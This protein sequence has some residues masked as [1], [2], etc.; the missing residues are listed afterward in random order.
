MHFLFIYISSFFIFVKSKCILRLINLRKL[1]ANIVFIIVFCV[2]ALNGFDVQGQTVNQYFKVKRVEGS[3]KFNADSIIVTSS[4]GLQAHDTILLIQMTGIEIDQAKLVK[5]L[6]NS[7]HYEFLLIGSVPNDSIVVLASPVAREYNN[8]ELLQAVKV[9]GFTNYTVNTSLSTP[10]WDGSTGGVFA[11]ILSDTLFLQQ[12]IDVSEKGYR[13][14]APDAFNYSGNCALVTSG[15]DKDYYMEDAQDIAA[16]KGEG[17]LIISFPYTRGKGYVQQGG[18]G[19]NGHFSGGGGGGNFGL[20]GSGGREYQACTNPGAGGDGGGLDPNTYYS[21]AN[22][23]I[24]MGGGGGTSTQNTSLGKSATPGGNGGGIVIILTRVLAG[25]GH[26]ISANGGSVSGLATAGGGGGGGGGAILLDAGSMISG[27]FLNAKGGK[28]GNSYSIN[29]ERTGSGGGGGGGIVWVSSPK[30]ETI[31]VGGGASG[32]AFPDY[33]GGS[34]GAG[35]FLTG[36][37]IPLTGFLYNILP[38]DQVICQ[39]AVPALIEGTAAKGGDGIYVYKWIQSQ[40]L[41]V[42]STISGANTANYQPPALSD[43]TYYR[44]IVTSH[45]SGMPA[46]I[47]DTSKVMS[48]NV[49]PAI[50]NNLISGNDTV[51]FNNAPV[52]LKADG[53]VSG[54]FQG[55]TYQWISQTN[56]ETT[57][58]NA[59]S[60]QDSL[61]YQPPALTSTTFYRRMVT[62]YGVCVDTSNE[63]TIT[64]LDSIANNLIATSQIICNNDQP[65]KLTGNVL[66]GGDG[67]YSLFWQQSNTGANWNTV[68]GTTDQLDYLP[69]VLHDTTYYRRI[70]ISGSQDACIDTSNQL[71]INVLPSLSNNS[72]SSSQLLCENDT[73]KTL[74]GLLPD[75]GDG[76]FTYMWQ[77]S[78]DQTVWTATG[79]STVNYDP[80][81]VTNALYYRRIVL[82]GAND[83]CK[84]TSSIV[85]VDMQPA[86][87]NNQIFQDTTICSGQNPDIITGLSPQGGDGNNYS[88]TWQSSADADNWS[89][90]SGTIN[91]STYDPPV[92]TNT[93]YVRRKVESGV[94]VSNSNEITIEVLSQVSDNTILNGPSVAV[95]Y[96]T[97][98]ATLD[99]SVPSGGNEGI[100]NYEWLTSTDGNNWNVTDGNPNG[101]DYSPGALT[102]ETYYK[103][104]V[105]SGLHG[106]CVDTSSMIT[107]SINPLPTAVLQD[108]TDTLCSGEEKDLSVSLTGQSPWNLEYSDGINSISKV[109]TG[110]NSVIA[111][112]PASTATYQLVSVT[113][114]NGCAATDIK[115]TA[116]IV[117][118]PV[119]T[120]NAGDNIEECGLTASLH[121]TVTADTGYWVA[122][123]GLTFSPSNSNPSS[124]VI[125]GTYGTYQLTWKV[126]NWRCTDEDQIDVTFYEQ[127]EP[128]TAGNE[129]DLY[130]A[131]ETQLDASMPTAGAGEW[132]LVSGTGTFDDKNINDTYIRGLQLGENVLKWTVSN[133]VCESL[134]GEVTIIRNDI[135]VPTAFS[136]DGNTINDFFVIRGLEYADESDIVI[137]NRWGAKVYSAH[138]YQDQWWDGKNMNGVQL[139]EDT[140]FYVLKVKKGTYS[141]SYNGYIIL[142]RYNK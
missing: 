23:R 46:V 2:L 120:A 70:A 65:N 34:G 12:N 115:G 105:L 83:V 109:I 69:P 80:G 16:R 68:P 43:T 53:T 125:S 33:L 7:G 24:F 123:G 18:G 92:L 5:N 141:G 136:P 75:G 11:M 140:Y 93:L 129:Q 72:I 110:A 81:K 59:G 127:P 95:C 116:K 35:S 113:D 50:Q 85:F 30:T 124:S 20:G 102:N 133:G 42:W 17:P 14:A 112:S 58:S 104:I 86:I 62:S 142:R 39:N 128:P 73:A 77:Q 10:A 51:C 134:S 138:Q 71:Q 36:L 117:V 37:S 126:A 15:Y 49:I 132:S 88:F 3:N 38:A 139:P 45:I 76:S 121:A 19:G 44:R 90:A 119:P 26:T 48:I 98:P 66:S 96:N 103:R 1:K 32:D 6:N 47:V 31:N 137:F 67:T 97:T 101:E 22:N 54:G 122:P 94:C 130:F 111:V 40:N 114:N 74:N 60:N 29:G 61:V 82:S 9:P 13:G 8:N 91:Q 57:W 118:F 4:A 108:Q 41:S 56:G 27:I 135:S 84:D 107:I 28:G 52:A 25:N 78:T 21:N 87:Q 64:V 99:G 63:L 89:A 100:Y 79:T 55:Y 131:T 106:C